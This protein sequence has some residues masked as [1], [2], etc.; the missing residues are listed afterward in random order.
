MVTLL[1][2]FFTSPGAHQGHGQN[3]R[4][5]L[6]LNVYFDVSTTYVVLVYDYKPPYIVFQDFFYVFFTTSINGMT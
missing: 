1:D 4:C 5:Y 3:D 2:I 6:L